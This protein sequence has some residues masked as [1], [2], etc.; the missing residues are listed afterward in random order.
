MPTP[1][2]PFT[3]AE[4]DANPLLAFHLK[5]RHKPG[6]FVREVLGAKPSDEQDEL[7][8]D[9]CVKRERQISVRSGHGTGKTTDLSWAMLH[10]LIFAA[11]CKVV[12]TAPAAGTLF[13]GLMAEV[14]TWINRMPPFLQELFDATTD[15]VR[16][17]GLLQEAFISARTSSSDKPEALAGIHAPRVLLV[18]DEA[19]GV[20]EAVFRA[21][22]GSM[23]TTGATTVL[24]GN[25]TR[26]SG[27]FFDT[28]HKLADYWK[29]VHWSCVGNPNVAPEY[30]KQMADQYGADSNEYRIRVL[31]EFPLDDGASYISRVLVD[32]AM[33]RSMEVSEDTVEVWGLDVARMGGDRVCLAKRRGPVI[34]SVDAWAGKDL[35]QTVGLVKNLWDATPYEHR[36]EEILVDA[37]GMGAGVVDRLTELGLPAIGVNVAETSGVLGV[38]MR[39]RD[40]LWYRMRMALVEHGLVLPYD[41]ELASELSTPKGEYHSNGK[42][43]VESKSEMKRRGFKSPDKADAVNLTLYSNS[44]PYDTVSTGHSG[45]YAR[46]YNPRGAL[47][48]NVGAVV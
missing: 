33:S 46:A 38:G 23:S 34:T 18:V 37:I 45:G 1:N 44:S 12:C 17:K 27:F 6:L 5:Y 36:P 21:A 41:E 19:S 26:N 42:L 3:K 22:F 32:E 14:K 16:I 48:S 47:T 25:P 11:P 7:L 10:T 8:N 24:I 9:I 13:D 39:M 20:P 31:G 30:I 15:H 4:L 28:H 43:K 29:R 40:E 2:A 35:M